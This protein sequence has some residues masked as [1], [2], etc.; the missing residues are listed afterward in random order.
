MSNTARQKIV[1]FFSAFALIGVGHF[2]AAAAELPLLKPEKTRLD[3]GR[4]G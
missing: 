1:A 2:S 3:V 4:P